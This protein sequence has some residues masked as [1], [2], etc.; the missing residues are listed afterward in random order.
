MTEHDRLHLL[1]GGYVLGGLSDEDHREFTEH[2]RTCTVCQQEL[3]QVSGLPRMLSF[4]DRPTNPERY[5]A[6]PAPGPPG[7]ESGA[8]SGTS[9]LADL[10]AEARRRR[11]RRKGWLA[12]AASVAA[13]AVFGA[14]V[15]LGPG[16]LDPPPPSEH[17][18]ATAATGS[19]AQVGVDLVERGWGTQLNLACSDMPVGEEI[20]VYVV[21][22]TGRE[23][24]AGSWLGTQSGYATVTGAT[25]LRPDQIRSI[26]VRTASGEVLATART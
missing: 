3:G 10:L 1:L 16:L 4:V 15:W 5:A 8:G 23:S 2:L 9:G 14:G 13:A 12:A 22:A 11:R 21:D 6:E 26:E 18:T 20:V 24:A 25:A 17:Y 7:G 19:S